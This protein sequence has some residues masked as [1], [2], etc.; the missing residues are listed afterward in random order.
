MDLTLPQRM[1]LLMYTPDKE[2]FEVQNLQFR[3]Q[4]VRAAALAQLF[5]QG[6]IG[7]RQGKSPKAVRQVSGTPGDSFLDE[8]WRGTPADEPKK[9]LDLLHPYAHTAESSVRE[10]LAA[11]G[12]ITIPPVKGLKKLS[13]LSQ[14]EV[15]VNRP[16]TVSAVRD[17]VRTPVLTGAD[18]AALPPDDLAMTVLAAESDLYHVFSRDE[19]REHKKLLEEFDLRF[20]DTIPG[21]RRALQTSIQVL[22]PSGGGWGS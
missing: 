7:I 5:N 22:R 6:L 14:H 20:D 11:T 16:E 4:K 8:V 13:L 17:Q 12:E 1:Y 21:L 18:P 19:R 9:W 2:K 15:L 3:G 10:Q